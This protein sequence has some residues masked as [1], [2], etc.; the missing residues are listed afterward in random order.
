M[1][2]AHGVFNI[3]GLWIAA[4]DKA[5]QKRVVSATSNFFGTFIGAPIDTS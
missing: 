5:D 4:E 2:R 1:Q 3:A